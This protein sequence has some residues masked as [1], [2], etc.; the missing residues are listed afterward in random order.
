MKYLVFILF[1]ISCVKE[2]FIDAT[3]YYVSPTGSDTNTGTITAPWRTWYY[4]I[5][6]LVAGD[7][8]YIRGGTYIS[9]QGSGGGNLSGVYITNKSGTSTNHIKVSMYPGDARPILDCGVLT[10]VAGYHRGIFMNNCNYWDFYGLIVQNIR[11]YSGSPTT[12]S[13]SAWEV[14]GG[15]NIRIE[16]C[17]VTNAMNGFSMTGTIYNLNYINCDSY[18]NYDIYQSGDLCNGFNGHME[19]ASTITYTGCRAWQNSDDGFDFMA[20][21]GYINLTNCWTWDNG[22]WHGGDA[23]G[24][25]DGFKI[26]RDHSTS[27]FN[28]IG[29]QRTLKNCISVSNH[30]IGIEAY[31]YD[32]GSGTRP[33][34]MV[35]YNCIIANN[36]AY[37]LRQDYTAGWGD[38]VVKNC[39]S[40]GNGYTQYEGY[41]GYVVDH[42]SWD[43]AVLANSADFISVDY[44]QLATV[45]KTDGSLPDVTAFHL[46]AGSD[47]IDKGINVALPFNGSAPDLGVF[48]YGTIP[49]TLGKLIKS[50]GKLI[51]K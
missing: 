23:S 43:L 42:N 41:S 47:L 28:G 49:S 15:S 35:F 45:R 34:D 22:P 48:E 17:T 13:G 14:S 5:N 18:S 21:A 50:K 9:V 25:G 29:S 6:K 32:G 19:A 37:G 26:V 1:L 16:Y 8:L 2:E 3:S 51:V 39:V 10:S 31:A 4:G 30:N 11:E 33:M 24:N 12:Y 20:G 44:N 46:V 7:I 27:T 40:Y 38:R 36:T